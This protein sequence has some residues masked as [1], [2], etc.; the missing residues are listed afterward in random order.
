MA[1]AIQ[2]VS[3]EI[4]AQPLNDN[5][6]YLNY[7]ISLH[8]SESTK[9]ELYLPVALT[10]DSLPADLAVQL[11]TFLNTC[12]NKKVIFPAGKTYNLERQVILNNLDNCEIDFNGCV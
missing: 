5:F 6:S 4:Q 3:G 1:S 7:S 2:T 8:L 9:A 12:S 10:A 11:E